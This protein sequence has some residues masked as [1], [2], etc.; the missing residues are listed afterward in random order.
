MAPYHGQG[1]EPVEHPLEVGDDLVDVEVGDLGAPA[2]ADALGAVDEHH[3]QD[4]AVPLGLHAQAVVEVGLQQRVVV[5]VVDQPRQLA[6]DRRNE[7]IEDT[8]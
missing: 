3:G 1:F 5:H 2:G 4:G 8:K 6:A 7:G